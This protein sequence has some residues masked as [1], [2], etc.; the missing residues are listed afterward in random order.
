MQIYP[1]EKKEK[2]GSTPVVHGREPYV[3]MIEIS[4]AGEMA[5]WVRALTTLPKVLSSNPTNHM[6]AHNH[7]CEI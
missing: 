2:S 3:P 4:W 6:V 1:M 7:P 5:Q